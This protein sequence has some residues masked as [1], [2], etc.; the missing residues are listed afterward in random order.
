MPARSSVSGPGSAVLGPF[1]GWKCHWQRT[2]NRFFGVQARLSKDELL[3]K[4]SP[5]ALTEVPVQ[6]CRAR[7]FR[8]G[9]VAGQVVRV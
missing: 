8:N 6:R 2:R 3:K 1:A 5:T 4:R 7:K 9:L